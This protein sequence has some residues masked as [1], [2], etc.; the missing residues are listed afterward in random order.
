MPAFMFISP[1]ILLLFSFRCT[2][3]PERSEGHSCTATILFNHKLIGN[4][5]DLPQSVE[6]NDTSR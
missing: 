4:V 6:L 1:T 3:Y 5:R 2:V